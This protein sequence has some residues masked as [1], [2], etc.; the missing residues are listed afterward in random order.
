VFTARYGLNPYTGSP[1]RYRTPHSFNNFA[2]N[3]DIATT[4]EA[5]YRHIPLHF[6]HKERTPVH[7]PLQYTYLHWF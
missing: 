2:S 3:E 4:F 1:I 6:S 7:I 5:V